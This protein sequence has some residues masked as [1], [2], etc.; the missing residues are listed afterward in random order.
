MEH[1]APGNRYLQLRIKRGCE[2]NMLSN[3][4]S[5]KVHKEMLKKEVECLVL[6]GVLE[7]AND[8]EWGDPYFVQP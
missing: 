5:T 1:L 3:I 7:L 4:S 2:A 6:L 8:S